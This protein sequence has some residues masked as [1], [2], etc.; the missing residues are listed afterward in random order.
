MASPAVSDSGALF[1]ECVTN[2][3]YSFD[4]VEVWINVFELITDP[5]DV[6]VDVPIQDIDI[7]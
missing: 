7:R 6:V 4:H 3:V 2:T 1:P 5:P